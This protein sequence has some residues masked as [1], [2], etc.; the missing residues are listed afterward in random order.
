MKQK[1]RKAVA[2]KV[3]IS[4]SGKVIRRSTGQNH[5]NT[6]ETGAEKRSKRKDQELTKKDSKN[7]LRALPY[8]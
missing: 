4:K 7:V 5:Y 3:T 1:T 8:A 6:K 2:K